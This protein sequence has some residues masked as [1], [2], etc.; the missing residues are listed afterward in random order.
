MAPVLHIVVNDVNPTQKVRYVDV[1]E[2]TQQFLSKTPISTEQ[3]QETLKAYVLAGTNLKTIELLIQHGADVN[4]TYT[5]GDKLLHMAYQNGNTAV[6][7]LL[8]KNSAAFTSQEKKFFLDIDPEFAS[9]VGFL[10]AGEKPEP[11]VGFK[12]GT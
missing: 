8:L 12:P 11:T 3:L 7:N 4:Y 2:L 9:S 5:G 1:A 10:K 6:T